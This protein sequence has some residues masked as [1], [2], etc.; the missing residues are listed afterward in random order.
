MKKTCFTILLTIAF[1]IPHFAHADLNSNLA[2]WYTFDRNSI[3]S[4]TNNGK[5][6]DLSGNGIHA[7]MVNV[8][9]GAAASSTVGRI[10]Q[11][12][13][14]RG[15][16]NSVNG[17]MTTSAGTLVI[18]TGD[19]SI[20]VYAK[21]CNNAFSNIVATYNSGP[22][23]NGYALYWNAGSLLWGMEAAPTS[24]APTAAVTMDCVTW[25]NFVATYSNSG[26]RMI[27]YVDGVQKNQ[28]FSSQ[29]NTNS[30]PVG[31]ITNAH[32]P[33]FGRT[34]ASNPA[35]NITLDD[36]RFYNR[37][38]TANEAKTLYRRML[39]TYGK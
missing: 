32:F 5:V 12:I 13:N 38:L 2:A 21:A 37:E 14:W 19:F 27:L 3:A 8:F 20:S 39:A 35:Q 23:N 1:C 26:G 17:G 24:T 7:S 28:A 9:G 29:T 22:A 33:N 6:F 34:F 25:H 30:V 36:L 11:G 18:G 10:Q 16:N 15:I 31:N 4:Y